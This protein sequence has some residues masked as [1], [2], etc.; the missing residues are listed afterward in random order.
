MSGPTLNLDRSTLSDPGYVSRL[1]SLA[2]PEEDFDHKLNTQK[3][4]YALSEH[5]A[6]LP[7][8]E[9]GSAV[10]PADAIDVI[11][12]K[13]IADVFYIHPTTYPLSSYHGYG[14]ED[15]GRVSAGSAWNLPVEDKRCR[16]WI[17]DLL[18]KQASVFNGACR[19]YAPR[20][21]QSNIMVLCDLSV[22]D[23]LNGL[24]SLSLAYEDIR[25]AFEYY[26]EH[27]N[28][29]RPFFIAGHSQGSFHGQSLLQEYISGN[30]LRSRFVA[31]Y[32][33][34]VNITPNYLESVPD[35]P[36]SQ[37][38]YQTAC[39]ITYRTWLYPRFPEENE[40]IVNVNPLNW[41]NTRDLIPA[42]QHLGA[43]KFSAQQGKLSSPVSGICAAQCKSGVVMVDVT[44]QGYAI[45]WPGQPGN[46]HTVDYEL[47]YMDLRKN[48]SDRLN[49]Y[50]DRS[51]N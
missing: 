46:L 16:K 7:G 41:K 26:I 4:D 21:R 36:V 43:V 39:I 25:A 8:L 13:F 14:I 24:S 19:I 15:L 6:A 44:K 20:Y 37:S 17:D 28:N 2:W 1:S 47:F 11:E 40:D 34:G 51:S 23:G 27:Y 30:P 33:I 50:L 42:N 45:E 22:G 49:C 9:H 5:W 31:A 3:T 38:S 48:I 12:N 32:L 35:I 10:R 18:I 29:D